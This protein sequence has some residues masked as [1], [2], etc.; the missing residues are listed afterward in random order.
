MPTP[1][2]ALGLMPSQMPAAPT[3]PAD[4]TT[5]SIGPDSSALGPIV[6]LDFADIVAYELILAAMSMAFSH[7]LNCAPMP[8]RVSCHVQMR[9]NESRKLI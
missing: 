6:N 8:R 2:R 9:D 4:S 7:E 1:R 5:L 3:P